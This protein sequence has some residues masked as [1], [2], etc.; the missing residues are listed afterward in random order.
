MSAASPLTPHD[1]VDL[2]QLLLN[3]SPESSSVID[4][5][6]KTGG[7]RKNFARRIIDSPEFHGK[8]R[9]TFMH[10]LL[11]EGLNQPPAEIDH[12]VNDAM[13]TAMIERIRAQWTK[14]GEED[15]HWSVLT[16]DS[17]RANKLDQKAL[18]RFYASGQGSTNTLRTML[19]RAGLEIRG[20]V[21][22]ELGAGVGR[23]TR[24]LAD[25]FDKVVA[26][27]I[28]PG[29]LA[30]CREHMAASGVGNVETI[31]VSGVKDFETL[32]EFDFFYSIIVLQH[33]PPPIQKA[34]LRTLFKKL[35]A[36]GMVFFQ[37]PTSFKG[38][39]FDAQNY[40]DTANPGMEMH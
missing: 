15:P 29:N 38:Y 21:C 12:D 10:H 23:V 22:L 19:A 24:H 25:L 18:E 28:S 32:P 26:V 13:L 4:L 9:H 37:I 31:Q 16:S 3:R 27:D 11:N 7:D 39:S 8:F 6:V 17:Y 36:G 33:N 20:G 40:L 34:I 14:L 5:H 1:V 2:Y 30:L 35:R